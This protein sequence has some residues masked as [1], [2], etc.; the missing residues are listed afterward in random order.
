MAAPTNAELVE[1]SLTALGTSIAAPILSH[2]ENG[3]TIVRVPP[4]VQ[5]DVYDRLAAKQARQTR[6]PCVKVACRAPTG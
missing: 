2:A 3:R 1:D 5:L 6:R 4:N